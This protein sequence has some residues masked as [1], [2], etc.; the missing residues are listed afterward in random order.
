M[1]DMTKYAVTATHHGS[2]ETIIIAKAANVAT[3]QM[4]VNYFANNDGEEHVEY[5]YH[6][7]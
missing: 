4:L 1:M 7:Q 3:A 6:K 5:E 2:S